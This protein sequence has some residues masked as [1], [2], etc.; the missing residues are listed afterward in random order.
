MEVF[1]IVGRCWFMKRR[2]GQFS[3]LGKKTF[4]AINVIKNKE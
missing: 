1:S 2:Q 4:N 3:L